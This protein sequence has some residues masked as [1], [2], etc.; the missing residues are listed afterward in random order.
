MLKNYFNDKDKYIK[1]DL[2]D[3]LSEDVTSGYMIFGSDEFEDNKREEKYKVVYIDKNKEE[4]KYFKHRYYACYNLNNDKQDSLVF[5]MFNPSTAN[6]DKL[7][8]TIKNCILLAGEDYGKIEIIN[9]FS[10]R[11]SDIET[12]KQKSDCL[13]FNEPNEGF[14]EKFIKKRKVGENN[15]FVLAWG[16]GKEA[17]WESKKLNE[18]K[19][20]S[21][22]PKKPENLIKIIK[23]EWLK[24]YNKTYTIG[25]NVNEINTYNHHPCPTAWRGM[26]EFEK[27]AILNRI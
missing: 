13:K 2:S 14:I 16:Y 20:D 18:L 10:Y 27:I 8:P 21:Y 4:I 6:P 1:L 22:K 24:D 26:G 19:V 9:L 15:A 3:K 5:I 23:E 12:I 7:D 25:V 11:N 17:G